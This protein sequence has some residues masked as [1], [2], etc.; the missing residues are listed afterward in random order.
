MVVDAARE[1]GKPTHL[2]G[3]DGVVDDGALAGGDVKGGC[4]CRSG[5]SGCPRTGMTPSGWNAR[6]GLQRD[7]HL[8]RHTSPTSTA[9]GGV[10][11]HTWWLSMML[12]ALSMCRLNWCACPKHRSMSTP[13]G[14]H[15]SMPRVCEFGQ[16][17]ASSEKGPATGGSGGARQGGSEAAPRGRC[18]PTVP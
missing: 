1:C 7:L 11:C 17:V 12:P 15:G 8:I 18:S 2:H 13:L 16:S 9:Q 10:D 5:A 3:A 4:S 14:G 6:Q